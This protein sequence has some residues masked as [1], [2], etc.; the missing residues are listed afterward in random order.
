MATNGW[1]QRLLK[2]SRGRIVAEL[3]RGP[4][5][6]SELVE[7]LE[8]SANAVRSHIAALE[9]DGVIA[10][11]EPV[12]GGVGKPANVYRLTSSASTLT[13][14][15]YDAML[16]TVLEATRERV[17][18]RGYEAI[19][20]DVAGKLAGVEPPSGTFDERLRGA[21]KLLAQIG[22]NVEVQR[23]GNTVRLRG[24]DCPLAS[25]VGVHP[26]LCSVVAKVIARRLGTPVRD[27]CNRSEDLPRCCFETIVERAA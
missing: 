12:R 9:S 6:I 8:L 14:K 3:R 27:C 7:R 4:A 17:G 21:R 16:A 10:I 20:N 18:N 15:A 24:S 13:P 26:E 11:D 5:T 23:S 22:A 1:L 2:S 25:L 19:L